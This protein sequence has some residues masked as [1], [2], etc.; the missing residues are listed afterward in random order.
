M[1]LGGDRAWSRE[2]GWPI[3][4]TVRPF[5]AVVLVFDAGAVPAPPAMRAHP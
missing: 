4:S 3:A 2:P 5:P 1:S